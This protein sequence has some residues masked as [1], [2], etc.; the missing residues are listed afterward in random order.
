MVGIFAQASDGVAVIGSVVGIATLASIAVRAAFKRAFQRLDAISAHV[1]KKCD[2]IS[3]R[4]DKKCDE[5]ADKV[6]V[7]VDGVHR[8]IDAVHHDVLV[9]IDRKMTTVCERVAK[10]EAW[11]D[12]ARNK[13]N[14]GLELPPGQDR[15]ETDG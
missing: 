3:A 12:F 2:Q 15:K 4:V 6:D 11:S 9:P 5:V 8:R 13:L 14:G 10:L 1:N 7:K